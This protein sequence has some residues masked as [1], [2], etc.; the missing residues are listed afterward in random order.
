MNTIYRGLLMKEQE[1]SFLKKASWVVVITFALRCL[2]KIPASAYECFGFAGEAISIGLIIMALYERVLWRYNPFEKM[3][4]IFG[5]YTATLEYETDSNFK[6]KK[7]KIIVVQSLLHVAVKI[8]T[9]EITSNTVTSDFMYENG[10]Y[11]LYY[12]YITNP[13]SRYSTDNPIQYGTCRLTIQGDGLLAG[14]YWTTRKTKGDIT[15][16]EKLR[17]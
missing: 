7:I 2:I 10:E 16:K 11:V 6:K 17:Q 8:I 15:F 4:K 1:K 14:G 5:E 9:N 12:T 13:K 3:P